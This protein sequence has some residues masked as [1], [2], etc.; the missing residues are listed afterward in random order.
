M[1]SEGYSKV[2]VTLSTI[3]VNMMTNY[4]IIPSTCVNFISCLPSDV[5]KNCN[6]FLTLVLP[7]S[8]I[9]PFDFY[10]KQKHR[11]EG[12]KDKVPL[13]GTQSSEISPDIKS[14]SLKFS[15]RSLP[16]L[17]SHIQCPCT[18]AW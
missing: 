11:R 10:Q 15:S 14:A 17:A 8:E 5:F 13:R 9:K 6:N 12:R 2:S 3:F 18:R 7:N 4:D 1:Y 16:S